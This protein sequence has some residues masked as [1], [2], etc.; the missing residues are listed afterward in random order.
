MKPKN[1]FAF[2]FKLFIKFE[3]LVAVLVTVLVAVPVHILS[4]LILPLKYTS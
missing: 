4:S 1:P 2:V 3:V